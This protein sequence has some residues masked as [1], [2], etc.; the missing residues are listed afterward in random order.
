LLN[1]PD[2]ERCSPG[3]ATEFSVSGKPGKLAA[4][5]P[6]PISGQVPMEHLLARQ[7]KVSSSG[8]AA[9]YS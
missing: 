3:T 5:K 1:V 4:E 9:Y 6:E 2:A 8:F 7:L